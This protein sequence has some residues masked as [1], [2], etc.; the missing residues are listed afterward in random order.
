MFLRDYDVITGGF[1]QKLGIPHDFIPILYRNVHYD[2][3]I[4]SNDT[5]FVENFISI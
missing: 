3:L 5:C 4:G 2:T 1:P